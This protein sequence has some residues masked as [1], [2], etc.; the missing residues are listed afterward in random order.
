MNNFVYDNLKQLILFKYNI[1]V[2]NLR[3]TSGYLFMKSISKTAHSFNNEIM[4]FLMIIIQY[5][6]I[7][8]KIIHSLIQLSHPIKVYKI[9]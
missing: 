7:I 9:L 5:P 1:L 6:I 8:Y 2:N 4:I 3:F